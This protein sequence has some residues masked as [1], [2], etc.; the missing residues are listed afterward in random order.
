IRF[1]QFPLLAA[2]PRTANPV[3][4]NGSP[5]AAFLMGKNLGLFCKKSWKLLSGMALKLIQQSLNN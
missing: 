1:A 4:S 3:G 2:F 5:H